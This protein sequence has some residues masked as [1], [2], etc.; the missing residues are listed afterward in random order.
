MAKC[1]NCGRTIVFG[2]AT[3]GA[4]R[5]C[6]KPCRGAFHLGRASSQLPDGFILEKAQ[7]VHSGPCPKCGGAGP[8]DLHTAYSVWSAAIITRW[9]QNSEVCCR[10]CGNKA[11]LKATAFSALLGWWGFPWGLLVTPAQIIRNLGYM[12]RRSDQSRPSNELVE[13]VRGQLS[14]QLLHEETAVKLAQRAQ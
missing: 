14:A 10:P 1:A 4:N 6:G 9:S 12:V 3:D 8:V 13:V 11:K 5:F 2:G 7:L